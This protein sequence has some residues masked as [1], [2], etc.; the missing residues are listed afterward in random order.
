VD[1]L[2]AV[3]AQQLVRAVIAQRRHGGGIGVANQA[4][5]VHNPDGLGDGLQH[6]REQL[7]GGDLAAVPIA[8]LQVLRV[9]LR[10]GRQSSARSLRDADVR[11]RPVTRF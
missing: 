8:K 2:V 9:W 10:S 5:G 3:A 11:A 4:A 6:R 1:G 7:V